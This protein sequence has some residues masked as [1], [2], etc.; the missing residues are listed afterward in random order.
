MTMNHEENSPVAVRLEVYMK[1]RDDEG[2][3]ASVERS[4]EDDHNQQEDHDRRELMG[5]CLQCNRS[6]IILPHED[7]DYEKLNDIRD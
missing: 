4:S 7:I 1:Y 2:P 6:H 5:L 3:R